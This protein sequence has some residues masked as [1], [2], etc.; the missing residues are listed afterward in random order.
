MAT[1]NI[2]QL[3]KILYKLSLRWSFSSSYSYYYSYYSF[4]YIS[5]SSIRQPKLPMS[6]VKILFGI[7]FTVS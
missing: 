4:T 5:A 1:M 7:G 2:S 6:G 3:R